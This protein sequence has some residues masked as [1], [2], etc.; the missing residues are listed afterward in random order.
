MKNL[1]EYTLTTKSKQDVTYPQE[2]GSKKVVTEEIDVPIKVILKE[3]SRADTEKA[4]N[5]YLETWSDGVRRG[6]LTR[7]VLSKTYRASE[8]ILTKEE[9]K[10]LEEVQVRIQEIRAEYQKIEAADTKSEE[11]KKK[12]EDLVNEFTVVNQQLSELEEVNESL[13]ANSVE[14][15]AS[16]KQN[17]WNLLFLS[18]IEKDGKPRPVVEG[19]TLEERLSNFDKILD[20]QETEEDKQRAELY[21][22][23]LLR[24]GFFIN[25]LS[26]GK[27]EQNQLVEINRQIDSGEIVL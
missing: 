27:I 19:E 6:L 21:N 25:M 8:G 22:K 15:L 11:D 3:P 13:Y 4:K 2:D 24:N 7:A 18:F 10:S 1:I 17:M 12:I 5:V 26:R 14:N 16:Q 20:S 23:I 9:I